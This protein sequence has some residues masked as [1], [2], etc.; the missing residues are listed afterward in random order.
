MKTACSCHFDCASIG[1]AESHCGPPRRNTTKNVTFAGLPM[2]TSSVDVS[3][4]GS[5]GKGGLYDGRDARRVL[6][7]VAA[8]G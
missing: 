1:S 5:Q 6:A 7:A 8:C 4:R 3:V 2:S